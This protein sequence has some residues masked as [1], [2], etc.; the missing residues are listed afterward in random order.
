MTESPT[1]PGYT[2]G[3][4]RETAPSHLAFA[5]LS[6][7]KSPGHAADPRRMLEL[8]FGQGF[9]LA[10]L[11][12]ANP[13]VA[14]EGY[15]FN[16]DHVRHAQ[17]L[18]EAAQ[19]ANL[20][21]SQSSFEQAAQ[22]GGQAD[23]DTIA[24]HGV[25]SWVAPETQQAIV[26]IVRQRLRPQG[27]LYVS[28]NCLA[29]WAPLAPV[30]Q[31]MMDVGRAMPGTP[32]QQL[33]QALALLRT[34]REANA[35]YFVTHPA[36]TRHVDDLLQMD[37]RYLVHEFLGDHWG[38]LAFSHVAA[39]FAGAGLSFTAS[40]TLTEN[41]D[42]YAVRSDLLP[43]FSGAGDPTLQQG[44][45]DF[46]GAKLFR[47]DVFTRGESDED[48]RHSI[49]TFPDLRFVLIVPRAHVQLTFFT[50]IAKLTGKPE[51]YTP[52]A[53]ALSQQPRS[54]GE[55]VSLPAFGQGQI[56][57]LTECLILLVHSGQVLPVM[58]PAAADAKPAQRFNRMVIEAAR[59]GRIYDSLACPVT[60]TGIPVTD[61]GLLALV[62]VF[63]GQARDAVEA[64][65]YALS[66]LKRLDRRPRRG[67]QPIE[68]DAEATEFLAEHMRPILDEA[69]PL[70]R[71]LG[72]L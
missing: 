45:R 30:R 18:I 16:P 47:R 21:V 40:A 57:T 5:A 63:D 38:P 62:A 50:P 67:G 44:V 35:P 13:D 43:F 27:L 10:L 49:A 9:G 11:A 72:A 60:G 3:F 58:Q 28:Y 24:L 64:A 4:Y 37:P 12:A 54:F 66:I 6:T 29:G 41:I 25:L 26:D 17:R 70:W 56:D 68:D 48:K 22:A 23:C 15:D 46:A 36:A 32:E 65:G 33:T 69:I 20:S 61:F 1:D 19:L 31:L 7:G 51:L 53:D 55:L 14:F 39:L 71:Q 52:L 34:L 42:R 59:E 8:G 2:A